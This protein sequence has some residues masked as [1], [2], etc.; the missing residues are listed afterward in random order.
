MVTVS[1]IN[2]TES[3]VSQEKSSPETQS[4]YVPKFKP[5]QEGNASFK[6]LGYEKQE[7]GT[8]L[9]EDD[10]RRIVVD[11]K[12][13]NDKPEFYNELV[14]WIEKRDDGFKVYNFSTSDESASTTQS[15]VKTPEPELGR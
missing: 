9:Y 2:S 13:H 4:R 3:T 10:W 1:V 5:V 12:N 8:Y 7:D 15:E 6:K 14:D 11:D